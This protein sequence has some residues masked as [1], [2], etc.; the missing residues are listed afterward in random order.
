MFRK[1]ISSWIFVFLVSC[2]M[3]LLVQVGVRHFIE[4]GG[5][6]IV[7]ESRNEIS[8]LA[9][10]QCAGEQSGDVVILGSSL[11]ERLIPGNG[12]VCIG[13]PGSSFEAGLRFLNPELLRSGTIVVIEGNHIFAGESDLMKDTDTFL[14]RLGMKVKPLSLASRPSA[15][16]VSLIQHLKMRSMYEAQQN[17]AAFEVQVSRGEVE[18]GGGDVGGGE[19]AKVD[20]VVKTIKGIQRTGAKVVIAVFPK[21]SGWDREDEKMVRE[22]ARVGELAGVTVVDYGVELRDEVLVFQD[23]VHFVPTAMSTFRFRNT[24]ARDARERAPQSGE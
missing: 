24:I 1:K 20:E 9:R 21:K 19:D 13:V 10:L 7:L 17:A 8:S 14:F 4:V 23:G 16:I 3:L 6:R 5:G 15:L 18:V 12:I 22:V 2:A 11:T